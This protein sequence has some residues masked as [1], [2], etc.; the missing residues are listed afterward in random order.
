MKF[1]PT[2]DYRMKQRK[3]S[4]KTIV[5]NPDSKKEGANVE[6]EPMTE[7]VPEEEDA[8][9]TQVE[10]APAGDEPEPA[11]GD[12]VEPAPAQEPMPEPDESGDSEEDGS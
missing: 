10:P 6:T 5:N 4:R 1:H 7:A 8:E 2:I 3:K 11:E 12:E 9:S